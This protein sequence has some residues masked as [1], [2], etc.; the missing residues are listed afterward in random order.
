MGWCRVFR[1]RNASSYLPALGCVTVLTVAFTG[2]A[3]PAPEPILRISYSHAPSDESDIHAFATAFADELKRDPDAPEVALFAANALGEEREVFEGMQLG[4]GASCAISG[5]AILSSFDQRIG[6]LDYPYLWKDPQQA[7][8]VLDG[9]VG[10][11][12]ASYLESSGFEVVA[13]LDSWGMRSVATARSG[14]HAPEDL[15]GLKLRTIPS[16]TYIAAMQSIGAI[17]SPMDFGEIHSSLET[18]VIDG[19]EHTPSVIIANRFYEVTEKFFRTDHIYGPLVLICS[20]ERLKQFAP[21]QRAAI[22]KAAAIARARHN[23]QTDER[24]ARGLKLLRS[25]GMA[26][27]DLDTAQFRQNAVAARAQ[28]AKRYEV[29]DLLAAIEAQTTPQIP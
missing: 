19:F 13:W 18:G 8:A 4:A 22:R 16:P 2:C 6:I 27:V 20:S 3:Q 17:A 7:R 29:E 24:I 14:R 5:S 9:D 1:P 26:I 23:A 25:Q 10:A 11:Q 21:T 15:S 12:L 28:L